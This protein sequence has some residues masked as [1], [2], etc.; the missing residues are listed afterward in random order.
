[1][2]A[3]STSALPDSDRTYPAP[4]ASSPIQTYLAELHA[5]LAGLREGTAATY[6]PELAKADPEWFGCC[7]VT[8]DGQ[9]YAVGDAE[10]AFTIQSLSKPFVYATALAD[11][12][13]EAVLARI[14]VEPTGDA[15][16]A[17]S[18]HPN[19][20]QPSNPMINAGAIASTGLV[21]GQTPEE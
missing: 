10:V 12:G 9:I 6:I 16:N 11:R 1:M 21:A 3:S 4:A 8:T 19:T 17:I 18:L 13:K 20:G 14:G 5:R 7:L 2:K 15:F